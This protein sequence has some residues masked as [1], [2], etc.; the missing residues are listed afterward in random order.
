MLNVGLNNF[1]KKGFG[2]E[3]K[4]VLFSEDIKY[5]VDEII[6]TLLENRGFDYWWSEITPE[7]DEKIRQ[8][9]METVA[10]CL[11]E[12]AIEEEMEAEN[13]RNL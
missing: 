5:M 10:R 11:E 13:E 8:K 3:M 4:K 7:A 6:D 12:E 1:N 9:L 2:S